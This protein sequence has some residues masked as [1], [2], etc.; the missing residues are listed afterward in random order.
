MRLL[1]VMWGLHLGLGFGGQDRHFLLSLC[2]FSPPD[3]FQ[4]GEGEKKENKT[5]NAKGH[6]GLEVFAACKEKQSGEVPWSGHGPVCGGRR[7]TLTSLSRVPACLR[8]M[9]RLQLLLDQEREIFLKE[10]K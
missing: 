3:T 9:A 7:L 4:A 10:A 1:C 8:T 5:A 2:S 6:L